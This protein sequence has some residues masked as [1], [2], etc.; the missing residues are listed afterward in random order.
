MA[1]DHLY[2]RNDVALSEILHLENFKTGK[3]QR[4]FVA[5]RLAQKD[6]RLVLS[7]NNSRE[8]SIVEVWYF[9]RH[10]AS[11]RQSPKVRK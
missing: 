8:Q 6:G 3:R 4:V 5:Y 11:Y 10:T 2:H 7:E 1:A 9:R